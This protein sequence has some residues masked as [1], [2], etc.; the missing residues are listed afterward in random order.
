MSN[1]IVRVK[2]DT[3]PVHVYITRN[4]S[5][6]DLTGAT[7]TM[8]LN[9]NLPVKATDIPISMVAD[10]S[11]SNKATFAITEGVANLPPG[12]HYGEI[13]VLSNDGTVWTAKQFKWSVNPSLV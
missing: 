1:E 2:G 8:W 5:P 7:V 6:Y 4:G 13:K 11:T 3:N 9:K 12:L 10:A